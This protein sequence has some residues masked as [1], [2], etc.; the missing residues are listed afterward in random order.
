MVSLEGSSPGNNTSFFQDKKSHL[1][2]RQTI[3]S[4]PLLSTFL[5]FLSDFGNGSWQDI[6]R[7]GSF[8]QT[9]LSTY[10]PPAR[11]STYVSWV[12]V[13]T[14]PQLCSTLILSNW[15]ILD[16]IAMETKPEHFQKWVLTR[17][18]QKWLIPPNYAL[19]IWATCQTQYICKLGY[20]CSFHLSA[21]QHC[22]N[23]KLVQTNTTQ[24]LG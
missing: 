10:P 6:N 22:H 13:E 17:Y 4:W 15:Q 12:H 16:T 23:V 1:Q 14:I 11:P 8:H 5:A 24:F 9:T 18:K 3:Y 21:L 20:I 19:D 7:S 2:T